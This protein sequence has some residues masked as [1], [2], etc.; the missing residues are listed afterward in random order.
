MRNLVLL[1]SNPASNHED[2]QE[3]GKGVNLVGVEL[4]SG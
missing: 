1:I 3:I 2:H 4:N